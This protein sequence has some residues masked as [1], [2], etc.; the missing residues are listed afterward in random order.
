MATIQLERGVHPAA[1]YAA[2]LVRALKPPAQQ[3]ALL[4]SYGWG[5]GAVRQV[6]QLLQGTK[7]EIAGVIEAH[8]APRAEH[9]S[10]AAELAE[11]LT[12][13]WE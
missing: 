3:A 5:G 2:L 9:Y 6:E 12:R 8:G 11:T 13:G 7:L 10:Q 4:T 1:A